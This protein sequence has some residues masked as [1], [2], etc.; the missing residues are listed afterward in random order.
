[1]A[2]STPF[3]ASAGTAVNIGAST[4]PQE[5]LLSPLYGTIREMTQPLIRSDVTS[6]LP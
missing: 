1:M 4:Y 6:T 3:T 2:V 5:L